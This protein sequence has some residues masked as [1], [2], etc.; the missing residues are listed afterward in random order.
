MSFLSDRDILKEMRAGNIICEPFISENLSNSSLDLRLGEYIYAQYKDASPIEFD[1]DKNG[2]ITVKQDSNSYNKRRLKDSI[3]T[4]ESDTYTLEPN[5]F[6]LAQTLEYVG[7]SCSHIIS[8]VADKSTLARLGLS[9]C[10][11][12]GYIDA[13]NVLNITLELKNN[14]HTPIVLKYGM[15]ICQ[16]KFAY[17]NSPAMDKYQGKYCNSKGVELAI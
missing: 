1:L 11:S 13:G 6:V 5:Q 10:F 16:L 17:L 8:E 15:H 4:G 2:R 7:Q 14:G 9:V 3:V 12:A